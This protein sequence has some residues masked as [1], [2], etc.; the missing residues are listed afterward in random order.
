MPNYADMTLMGHV[1]RSPEIKEFGDKKLAT[2]SMAV[3]RRVKGEKVSDWFDVKAWG[4]N[5][6]FVA[7]YVQKGSAILVAGEPQV[8]TWDAKDGGKR[9]KVV[10]NAQRVTFAG[11]KGDSAVESKPAAEPKLDNIPF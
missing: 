4:Y 1:G 8:E 9:S 11:S 2:F 6:D 5:A 10:L 7:N 3:S